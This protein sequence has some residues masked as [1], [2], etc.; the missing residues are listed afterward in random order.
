MPE[1]EKTVVR[2]SHSDLVISSHVE[3]ETGEDEDCNKVLA[4]DLLVTEKKQSEKSNTLPQG[5]KGTL[6]SNS[7]KRSITLPRNP[8]AVQKQGKKLRK[9]LMA[10]AK[11][12]VSDKDNYTAECSRISTVPNSPKLQ[13]KTNKTNSVRNFFSK[14]VSQIAVVNSRQNKNKNEVSTVD[15][16]TKQ[17]KTYFG[18]TK[19]PGY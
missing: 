18:G 7:L 17:W 5:I 13:S 16:R 3:E 19:I 11:L 6:K 12:S 9:D 8:F 4:D 14:V 10:M 15:G 2:K 1:K